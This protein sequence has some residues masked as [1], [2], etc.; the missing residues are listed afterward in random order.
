MSS[1]I[2]YSSVT[3]CIL[4]SMNAVRTHVVAFDTTIVDLSELC[5]DPVEL[6]YGFPAWRGNPIS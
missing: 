6:L 2:L 5:S 4:A 1:S 3:A